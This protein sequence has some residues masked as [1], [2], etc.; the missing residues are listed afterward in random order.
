RHE[1]ISISPAELPRDFSPDR[2]YPGAIRFDGFLADGQFVSDDRSSGDVQ[3]VDSRVADD[4]PD[5]VGKV[6][7]VDASEEVPHS[8]HGVGL[9][10]A[11]RRLKI[12]HRSAVPGSADPSGGLP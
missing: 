1:L 8:E 11:E 10:T 5:L 7:R 2:P 12:D 4:C 6:V 3:F 9:A